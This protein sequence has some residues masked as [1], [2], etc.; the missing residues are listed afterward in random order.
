[1]IIFDERLE[2]HFTILKA[3]TAALAAHASGRG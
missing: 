2:I 3:S 1:M